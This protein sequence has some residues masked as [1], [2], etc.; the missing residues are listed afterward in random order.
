MRSFIRHTHTDAYNK[1]YC[2][3]L[4]PATLADVLAS[5]W[6]TKL[7]QFVNETIPA[8]ENHYNTCLAAH[9][10]VNMGVFTFECVYIYIYR[11]R[12]RERDTY[13]PLCLCLSHRDTLGQAGLVTHTL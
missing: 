5:A 6:Q 8:S 1:G 12:E 11:E 2:V 4:C 3:V 9:V 10:N 13:T 7:V